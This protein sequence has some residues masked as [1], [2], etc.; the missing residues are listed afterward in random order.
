MKY[1]FYY[2]LF[3]TALVGSC[4]SSPEISCESKPLHAVSFDDA[5]IESDSDEVAWQWFLNSTKS[6]ENVEQV[7]WNWQELG[8]KKTPPEGNTSL[9]LKETYKGR[10]N[11]TGR[12]NNL[13]INRIYENQVFACS[14]AGGLF[15]SRNYGET[16]Q[17]AGTDKL[18]ISGVSAVSIN[19]EDSAN[20]VI[21]TGDGDDQF[22]F[23]DGV[24]RTFN[25]G[26][27][28]EQV[29]GNLDFKLPIESNPFSVQISKII[30]H[31]CDFNKQF[32]VS[33]KGFYKSGNILDEVKK[34]KWRRVS[35]DAY[36]D[37]EISPHDESIVIA[38]GTHLQLS[39]NC[40]KTF[41]RIKRPQLER[42]E[43][44]GLVRM[45]IEFHP[46]DRNIIY[47]GISRKKALGSGGPGVGYLFEY[48]LET[49]EWKMITALNKA[50]NLIPTRGRAFEVSPYQDGLMLLGN[51][52]PVRRS[53][54][55]GLTFEKIESNQMHDDIHDFEFFY[56]NKKVLAAHDGGV[57]ISYDYG[58]TWK[59]WD[60]GIGAAC[61]HGLDISQGKDP[62]IIYGAYDTGTTLYKNG[63]WT[64]VGFG[65]GFE[66]VIN[67]SDSAK[68][69]LSMQNGGLYFSQNGFEFEKKSRAKGLKA[70]WHTWVKQNPIQKDA[71]YVS[72]SHVARSLDFGQTWEIIC[73]GKSDF[74]NNE[75]PWRFY[76]NEH[77]SEQMYTIGLGKSRGEDYMYLTK[78]LND[79]SGVKWEQLGKL[80]Y[81]N[82]V[83]SVLP[84]SDCETCH[85]IT[86]ISYEQHGKV[87][88][89]DGNS[90]QTVPNQFGNSSIKSGVIDKR[91]DRIYVGTTSGVY[92]KAHDSNDWKLLKGLPNSQVKSMKI[93]YE[94]NELFVGV[95]GRGIWKSSLYSE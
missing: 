25:S 24:Y 75:K 27:N 68:M 64:H 10:G 47:V 55:G 83:S 1:R 53:T 20:W 7:D 19:P 76:L 63:E 57:S 70:S 9:A 58:K 8:P 42:E 84:T 36:Y 78:N 82:W 35:A 60:N 72:G 21:S 52:S 73:D 17:N 12:I 92:T 14:P 48:H 89:Y 37:V 40:G 32:L 87:F 95:F 65:D 49:K 71:I 41:K 28:W 77:N 15:C 39:M 2:I 62:M 6:S 56:N 34:V 16:W 51:V 86:F 5:F 81:S 74:R 91:T 59:P 50:G 44:Y 80:P 94:T 38:G 61:V 22:A 45:S 33:N 13:V 54:D 3:L 18:P 67:H 79:T 11:G 43:K 93:N 88:Y 26:K 31:P 66:P 90:Y 29:N 30:S 69:V 4:D 23:S 46:R 85:Y